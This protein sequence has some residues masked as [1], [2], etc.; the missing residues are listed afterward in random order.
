MEEC[1]MAT[2]SSPNS[3]SAESNVA[4]VAPAN[5]PKPKSP[6]SGEGIA[7]NVAVAPSAGNG[8]LPAPVNANAPAEPGSCE[9]FK[10]YFFSTIE[11]IKE[12]ARTQPLLA[13][14]LVVALV[15][16]TILLFLPSIVSAIVIGALALTAAGYIIYSLWENRKEIL[17]K[18][19]DKALSTSPTPDAPQPVNGAA[20][21]AATSVEGALSN[22]V[23]NVSSAAVVAAANTPADK[24]ANG[25]SDQKA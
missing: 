2:V 3:R 21:S 19:M 10:Q 15:A 24:P 25:V 4:V 22:A 11:K 13:I 12:F 18:Y 14:I 17:M 7:L 23:A 9:V 16:L 8:P 1:C 20:R 6:R 5:E